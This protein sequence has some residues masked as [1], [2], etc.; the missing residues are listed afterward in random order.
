MVQL[1]SDSMPI[2][3]EKNETMSICA[4]CKKQIEFLPYRIVTVEDRSSH[5]CVL[6]FHYFASCWNID[7]FVPI[8]C[9]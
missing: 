6:H 7:D 9:K 8:S 2:V 5:I 1:H 4:T 3:R